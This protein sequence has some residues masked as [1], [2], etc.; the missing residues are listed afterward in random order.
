MLSWGKDHCAQMQSK[1]QQ[2]LH[3]ST[4]V[5]TP[6][7][8]SHNLYAESMQAHEVCWELYLPEEEAEE[9]V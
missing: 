1:A 2:T 9:E 5:F 4:V 6:R 7:Q 3:L 8:H